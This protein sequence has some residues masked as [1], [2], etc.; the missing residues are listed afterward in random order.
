M[1][2][3]MGSRSFGKRPRFR[4]GESVKVWLG[5]DWTDGV[6]VEDRG[7]LGANGV[8]M[9]RVTISMTA[10]E[11]MSFDTLEEW[12][13]P[14]GSPKDPSPV[15]PPGTTNGLPPRSEFRVGDRIKIRFGARWEEGVV[16]EDRGP[17][18]VGGRQLYR[19]RVPMPPAEP[20]ETEVSA[21]W[22]VP[23]E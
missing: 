17:L 14:A 8:H 13:A 6:V 1:V 19:I 7:P 20:L 2:T 23:V 16:V 12:I 15:A 5:L 3:K 9:Y 11:P 10:T 21:E 22:L 4:V 18:G